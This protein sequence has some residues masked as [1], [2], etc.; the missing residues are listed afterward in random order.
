M[1]YQIQIEMLEASQK[2]LEIKSQQLPNTQ[3]FYVNNIKDIS[4]GIEI[5]KNLEYLNPELKR[6]MDLGIVTNVQ[7]STITVNNDVFSKLTAS[8]NA[9]RN[10]INQNLSILKSTVIEISESTIC[11]K[12]IEH[13]SLK[14]LGN[15]LE[16]IDTILNQIISHKDVSG[17]YKFSSF[18][19]G[20]TWVYILINSSLTMNLIAGVVW[21]ACVIR[22]KWLECEYLKQ[23]IKLMKIKED[24]LKDIQEASDKQ[25]K[26]LTESE[27]KNIMQQFNLDNT[28]NEYQNRLVHSITELSKL[29]NEGVQVQPSLL[30]PEES[31]NLFPNYKELDSIQSHT[32]LLEKNNEKKA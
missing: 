3:T 9:L 21:S 10:K 13:D 26:L 30:V 18:D 17:T 16:L 28:D 11:I 15:E 31:K 6:V 20:S 14:E 2:L 12:L 4:Q 32:K 22:K 29:I 23:Q 7:S 19:I 1:R 8:V 27:A 25:L 24:S 5:L